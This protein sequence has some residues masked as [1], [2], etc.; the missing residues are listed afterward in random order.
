MNQV[1][2]SKL[3]HSV[4]SKS[5]RNL[6]QQRKPS[7][8]QTTSAPSDTLSHINLSRTRQRSPTLPNSGHGGATKSCRDLSQTNELH[9]D[10]V[11]QVSFPLRLA[12]SEEGG[13]GGWLGGNAG[14]E[15]PVPRRK[16][17]VHLVAADTETLYAGYEM[18]AWCACCMSC[19]V[20]SDWWVVLRSPV[21]DSRSCKGTGEL[22]A[23][24]V[25][26]QQSS[27]TGVNQFSAGNQVTGG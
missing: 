10:S 25:K 1:T 5:Q 9:H 17:R 14:E 12:S 18:Y 3:R 7:L 27:H 11:N 6:V 23:T 4:Y 8:K 2:A 26:R 21:F 22:M 20:V 15:V 24:Q 16:W 19:V 13:V